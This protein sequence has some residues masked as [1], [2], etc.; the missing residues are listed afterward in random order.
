MTQPSGS[1]GSLGS[2][3]CASSSSIAPRP[4]C[5]TRDLPRITQKKAEMTSERLNIKKTRCEEPAVLEDSP[6]GR[7]YVTSNANTN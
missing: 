2:E 6:Y 3:S 7:V 1:P 4:S 5:E